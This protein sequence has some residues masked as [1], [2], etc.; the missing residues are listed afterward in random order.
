[1][2]CRFEE[3][4]ELYCQA[5]GRRPEWAEAH[6]S[7]G[8][9]LMEQNRL[10]EAISAFEEALLIEKDWYLPVFNRAVA[11]RKLGRDSEAIIGFRR[12]VAC[13]PD[14]WNGHVELGLMLIKH[15]FLPEGWKEYEWRWQSGGRPAKRATRPQPVWSGERF[16]GQTLLLCVEQGYGDM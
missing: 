3:A 5:I 16:E 9:A 8:T 15:G 10:A 4:V 1:T 13:R 2:A 14:L 11:L 12:A 7:M 6:N